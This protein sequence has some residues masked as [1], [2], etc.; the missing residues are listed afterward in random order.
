MVAIK[1][2]LTRILEEEPYIHLQIEL[3]E[4]LGVSREYVRQVVNEL[5]LRHLLGVKIRKQLAL[6][7]ECGESLSRHTPNREGQVCIKCYLKKMEKRK[8]TL[9]CDTC[10]KEFKRTSSE[11][12]ASINRKYKH[13]FCSRRCFGKWA[14]DTHGFGVHRENIGGKRMVKKIEI[15]E[16]KRAEVPPKTARKDYAMLLDKCTHLEDGQALKIK[17]ESH[18][19]AVSMRVSLKGHFARLGISCEISSRVIGEDSYIFIWKRD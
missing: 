15:E 3:A 12:N 17:C 9:T 5:H 16:I 13:S 18:G 19:H 1:D 8:R 6:C 4:E 2:K 11:V 7:P 14:G 10:G